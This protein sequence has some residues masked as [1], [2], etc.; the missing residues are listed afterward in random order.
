MLRIVNLEEIQSVLLLVPNLVSLHERR[1]AGFIA[2]VKNWLTALEKVLENNR[3]SAAGSVATLRDV[4]ISAETGVITAGIEFHGR[5]TKKK[6]KEATASKVLHEAGDLISNVIRKDSERVTEAERMCRQLVALAMA[7]GLIRVPS[8]DRDHTEDLRV[9]WQALAADTEIGIGT[10][11]MEGLV[12]PH[13]VLIVLDRT[14]ARD[15][16][17]RVE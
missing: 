11:N 16:A 12:G 15:V 6:V 10:R 14:L 9:L 7:K 4:L 1:D 13:D 2:G 3:M 17:C 5:R 8:E